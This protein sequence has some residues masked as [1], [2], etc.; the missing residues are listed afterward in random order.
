MCW[1]LGANYGHL[2]QDL[3][4]AEA[5]RETGIDVSFAISNMRLA[6]ERL[7][8]R[9]F[10]YVM[11]PVPPTVQNPPFALG[12]FAEILLTTGFADQ[13]T[14]NGLV[15]GWRQLFDLIRP[16]ALILDYA[17]VALLAARLS[18]RPALQ[19]STAFDVPP[20]TTPLPSML[21]PSAAPV[22]R[23]QA[24]E[25]LVNKRIRSLFEAAGAKRLNSVQ[26]LLTAA[27]TLLTT[28]PELDHYGTRD[29]GDYIGPILSDVPGPTVTWPDGARPHVFAYLRPSVPGIQ[30]LLDALAASGAAVVCAIPGASP[31]LIDR[32][33]S[34]CFRVLPRGVPLTGLLTE[35]DA[36]VSYGGVGTTAAA[37]LAGLPLLIVPENVEQQ[38]V[39]ARVSAM[40]AGRVV[41]G[42]RSQESFAQELRGLMEQSEPRHAARIFAERHRGYSTAESVQRVVK[43]INSLLTKDAPYPQTSMRRS[44]SPDVD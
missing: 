23:L 9:G 40:G 43:A 14:L 1:Q 2:G 21:P 33:Q 22:E 31:A 34:E 6:A 29:H 36:V 30:A 12:S 18:G 41:L 35:T 4:I 13:L 44:T 19:L 42:A 16:D 26:E 24:A 15:H 39:G 37:L 32:Y 17:P 38:L 27:P 11:A 28:F 20:A 3:P 5:L 10:R 8:P 25:S 7:A